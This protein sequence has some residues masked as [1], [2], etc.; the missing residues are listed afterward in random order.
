MPEVNN[1]SKLREWFRKC[2]YLYADKRFRVD[3][4]SEEPTE[5]ALMAT[6]STIRYI[7]NVLG[8][9][10][11]A[12]IQ[13]QNYVF[14]VRDRYSPDV[15]QNT[16]NQGFYQDIVNWIIERNARRDFPKIDEGVVQSIVPTLTVT[17][18]ETGP[19]SARYE[20]RIQVTYKRY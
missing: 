7:E 8:E 10:V 16:M 3:F 14:T 13:A 20:I 19:D 18:A 9:W 17:L 4:L 6:P 15:V 11:P 12:D 1:I 2:P 5:Y